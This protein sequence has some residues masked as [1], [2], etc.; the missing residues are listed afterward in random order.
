LSSEP[1]QTLYSL[2]QKH[3]GTILL[4][5]AGHWH[6][7]VD[8]SRKYGP[9]HTVIAATRYD[10]NAFMVFRADGRKGSVEW[11][12]SSLPQWATHFSAPYL[13]A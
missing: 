9:Q 5:V 10:P 12:D 11:I 4:V 8:F 3:S 7:W 2:L 6:R 1:F 13:N